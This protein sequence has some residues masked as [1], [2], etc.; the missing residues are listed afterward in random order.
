M[1]EEIWCGLQ[2]IY[3]VYAPDGQFL[4]N[5]EL[6]PQI[7]TRIMGHTYIHI[8]SIDCSIVAM[9][10]ALPYELPLKFCP[11]QS[12]VS[13]HSTHVPACAT[14]TSVHGVTYADE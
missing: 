3:F 12:C 7:W 14:E 10:S 2:Y 9:T 5:D 11:L 6:M 13:K 8:F 4:A 1:N